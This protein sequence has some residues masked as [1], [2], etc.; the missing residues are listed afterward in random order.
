MT[1]HKR[2][3]ADLPDPPGSPGSARWVV[4][5]VHLVVKSDGSVHWPNLNV[6]YMTSIPSAWGL[7]YSYYVLC[8]IVP[9]WGSQSWCPGR[10]FYRNL[11]LF[12]PPEI[13]N[14]DFLRQYT[15]HLP[16]ML[17]I[18]AGRRG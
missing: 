8:S 2:Q 14:A 17:G 15:V 11:G 18:G 6:D 4:A 10:N 5:P 13:D 7:V 9:V 12:S 16:M 3:P 1:R